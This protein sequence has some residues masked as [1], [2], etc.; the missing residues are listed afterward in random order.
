M[1]E[2]EHM[3]RLDFFS[4]SFSFTFYKGQKIPQKPLQ[5]LFP[6]SPSWRGNH[7]LPLRTNLLTQQLKSR[8]VEKS[9]KVELLQQSGNVS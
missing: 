6:F 2:P 9:I 3:L 8:K 1:R 7:R 4:L 5:L